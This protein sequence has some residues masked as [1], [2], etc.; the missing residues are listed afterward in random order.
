MVT[1]LTIATAEIC[2][3]GLKILEVSILGVYPVTPASLNRALLAT[4]GRNV[5]SHTSQSSS[6]VKLTITVSACTC[7]II[8][9]NNEAQ[10]CGLRM[11][12]LIFMTSFAASTVVVLTF[13]TTL[14][15]WKKSQ[16]LHNK[17]YTSIDLKLFNPIKTEIC[18]GEVL[19]F[20]SVKNKSEYYCSWMALSLLCWGHRYLNSIK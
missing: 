4:D 13:Q 10:F 15:S 14:I 1:I 7:Q 20:V 2:W 12:M 19:T 5:L 9:K 17:Q 6:H 18:F 8:K 3:N 11:C 16:L